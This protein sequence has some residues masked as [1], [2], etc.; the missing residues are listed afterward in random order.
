MSGLP[1]CPQCGSDYTCED[2]TMYV[3]PECAHEWA[4]DAPTGVA[5]PRIVRDSNGNVLQDGD[6]SR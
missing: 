5:D 1:G 2:R 4:K 6:T 3:C